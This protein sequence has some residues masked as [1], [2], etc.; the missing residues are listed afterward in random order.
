[1]I[2]VA[3]AL[4][5]VLAPAEAPSEPDRVRIL[6]IELAAD[7]SGGTIR[8]EAVRL[9]GTDQA[10]GFGEGACRRHPVADRVLEQL[11]AAMAAQ[12]PVVFETVRAGDADCVRRVRFL[13]GRG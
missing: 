3:L 6:A 1:M 7:G 5:T 9:A 4:L 12:A 13:S 2:A 8:T 11:F 10:I